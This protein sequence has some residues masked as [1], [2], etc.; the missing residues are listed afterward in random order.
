MS[1]LETG[2]WS[3]SSPPTPLSPSPFFQV[4]RLLK[5]PLEEL[6]RSSTGE[7]A[8]TLFDFPTTSSNFPPTS[9]KFQVIQSQLQTLVPKEMTISSLQ[10]PRL[11]P[12]LRYGRAACQ[13]HVL[14]RWDVELDFFSL[15]AAPAGLCPCFHEMA[16]LRLL[17]RGSIHRYSAGRTAM[18]NA[19][20]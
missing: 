10:L 13:G 5:Q 18:K 9:F 15:A 12:L 4:H 11:Y 20:K 8:L 14:Q 16:S 19:S 2:C 6:I 7:P 3:T 1:L 17:R